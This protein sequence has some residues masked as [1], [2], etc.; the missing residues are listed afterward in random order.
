MLLAETQSLCPVCLRLV[1]AG[2]HL[3]GDTV[4]LRKTCPEH[5]TFQ[6]PAW[7]QRE[8][9]PSFKIWRQGSRIPAYPAHPA[10]RVARGCPFDCGLCPEH[11]QHTCTGLIEVTMRCSL[12]CPVCYARA[13]STAEDPSL[14]VIEAQLDAL[15]RASGFRCR[16]AHV[17]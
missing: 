13:G 4:I 15:S 6:V 3:E 7:K 10:T 5:G 16:F 11:V 17:A 9:M 12:G 8:G 1:D 2:Y 14:E